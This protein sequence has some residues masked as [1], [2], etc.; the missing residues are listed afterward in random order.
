MEDI[1]SWLSWTQEVLFGEKEKGTYKSAPHQILGKL[2]ICKQNVISR[3]RQSD[4]SLQKK[5][6]STV[7]P[8]PTDW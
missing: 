2:R 7:S 5:Q 3:Y 6:L 4:W 8:S 1:N